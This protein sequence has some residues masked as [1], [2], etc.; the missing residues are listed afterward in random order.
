[1]QVKKFEA[2]TMQEALDTIKRELGPEAI[3]LQ[4][5]THKKGFGLMSRPSVEVTV[6][7]SDRSMTK[8]QVTE[9]RLPEETRQ[10]VNQM[11]ARKQ[12]DIYDKYMDKHLQREMRKGNEDRVEMSANS[13]SRGAGATSTQ[14]GPTRKLTATRYAD[15]DAPEMPLPPPQQQQSRV[16]QAAGLAQSVQ[17]GAQ[18]FTSQQNASQRP[19]NLTQGGT[20]MEEELKHLKR[21]IEE[22][23]T[24]QDEAGPVSGAQALLGQGNFSAPALQDAFEQLVLNG[25]DKRYALSLIKKV[26]FDLGSHSNSSIDAV[27]DGL[28]C[29]IMNSTEVASPIAHIEPGV[30]RTQG[31]IVIALVGPT[32]VGK[33]TTVAKVAS[34]ALLRRNLKVGLINLDSY[35]V[36][37]FDQLATYAKILNVPF[38]SAATGADLQAA[39]QDF[40]TL[41]VVFVDTT[42]RSQRD[43]AALKEMQDILNVIPNIQTELVLSA[44]TRDA[45]LYDM[46]NRFSVFKP[47]GIIVSKLDEATIFGAIYNVSQKV[48]LPLLYFTTGQRVPEDIEEASRERVAALIMDL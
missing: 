33:T 43:P 47:H 12:A 3:I 37:A 19:G 42:G 14:N 31:P 7:I 41:D 48:K 29:E 16:S 24:T 22:M 36:A 38:R 44:T 26:G 32:G 1:M 15:I 6:A 11:P 30:K 40:Q 5:R 23:K 27:L 4:T 9:K 8:K 20:A 46:A 34:E 17:S 13:K 21:M 35:K 18:G 45:E 28:A 39:I 2:P 25:I 10:Q